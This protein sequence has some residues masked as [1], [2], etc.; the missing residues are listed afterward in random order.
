MS[1][2]LTAGMK[3]ALTSLQDLQDNI[4]STNNRL[5]TGKKV[6][7]AL[8]NAL[9]FFVADSFSSKARGL[10]TI[11]DN[12]GLGLNVLKQT[13]KALNSMRASLD[14]AEGTLR[15]ALN[16]AGTNAKIISQASFR[17][18]DGSA[19]PAAAFFEAAGG[20]TQ[21]RLQSGD[22][23]TVSLVTLDAAGNFVAALGTATVTSGTATVQNVIDAINTTAAGALN[24]AGQSSRVSAYLNDAGNLVIENN[25]AGRDASGNT[26]AIR[27]NQ[28]NTTGVAANTLDVFSFS[29]AVGAN[30]SVITTGTASQQVTMA[31]S[32]SL[33]ET[34]RSAASSF[35]EVLTQIRNSALDAGYNGTNLLQGDFLRVG[36]NE[37]NTTSST[38]QGRR[39]DSNA[40]GF[41]TDVISA[42]TGDAV[43]DFQSDREISNALTKIRTAK[44]TLAGMQAT[45]ATNANI[46]TNRQDFNNSA[47]KN[48]NDGADLLTLADINEEGA[49]LTSLQT[50]Q[51]LSITAL[52]LANQSDQAIL[53]LF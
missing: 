43:R 14:Q 48:F 38:T 5:A 30:T 36:F 18:A 7:S 27:F 28:T 23:F 31:G 13:D 10:Q 51:Q 6:N 3:N 1:I 46:L 41:S 21:N 33:Q 26:Y 45:F 16:T 4:R 50:R 17:N 49:N 42:N 34:R 9:N 20:T 40:L 37:D 8:D 47:I 53:R 24:V 35:R 12:I 29:G 11:Q 52:S 25:L 2:S 44:S 32:N 22:T 19:N 39:L 15:A